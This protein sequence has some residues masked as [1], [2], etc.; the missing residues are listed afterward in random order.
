[1][2]ITA[3]HIAK[4]F[5]DR[6]VRDKIKIQKLTYIAFGFH[7]VLAN[8]HLFEEKIQAWKY[9]PAIPILHTS[10]DSL[11]GAERGEFSLKIKK[12]LD[13]VY[14]RYADALPF[15]LVDLTHRKG[16]PWANNYVEGENREIPK[17]EITEYYRVILGATI[18]LISRDARN[19]LKDF[20]SR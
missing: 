20:A 6:G 7:A 18:K 17:E 2:P 19:I 9:G 13:R 3:I 1:M 8:E 12:T 15:T 11:E 14:N 10:Y 5:Y 4:Y 16:T